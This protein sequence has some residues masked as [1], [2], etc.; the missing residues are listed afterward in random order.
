MW[1]NIKWECKRSRDIAE[2]SGAEWIIENPVSTM[3]SYWRKPDYSFHPGDY[4]DFCMSDNYSK[5]T[6]LWASPGVVM[7]K[8]AR[9]GDLP[10]MDD[11]IHKAPPGPG[12]ANFRSATPMGFARAFFEANAGAVA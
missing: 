11:R 7:P 2:W 1:Y 12:R 10:P 6:C 5:K 4:A 8:P 9:S 3:S